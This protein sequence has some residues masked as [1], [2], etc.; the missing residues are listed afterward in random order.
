MRTV[1]R[2]SKAPAPVGTY[3]QGIIADGFKLVFTSGQIA[4][5]PE[6]NEV[7]KGDVA[8]QTR[9]VLNNVKA[10]L[11]AAGTDMDKLVKVTVFMTD[12]QY[13]GMVNEVFKEFFQDNP[14]ARSAVQV[15]A[16]PKGVDVEIEG[17]AVIP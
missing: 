4:I 10:I 8:T 13:F 7:I 16:L 17:I 15:S 11:Q 1:I 6:R 3:N 5:D 9:L 12:L 14:P 2:T